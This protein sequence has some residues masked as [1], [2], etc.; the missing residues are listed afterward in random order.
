MVRQKTIRKK[1][2]G[3]LKVLFSKRQLKRIIDD[4]IEGC[5]A[6]DG[7]HND[8]WGQGYDDGVCDV[9]SGILIRI[10]LVKK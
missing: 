6:F 3:K 7:E 4:C 9:T 1:K 5:G 8:D 2:L 10:G